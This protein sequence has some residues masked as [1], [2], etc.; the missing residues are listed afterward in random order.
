[1]AEERSAVGA[2]AAALGRWL[3]TYLV[4]LPV[5]LV[6]ASGGAG[7]IGRADPQVLDVAVLFAG[8]GLV[9]TATAVALRARPRPRWVVLVPPVALA[10]ADLVVGRPAGQPLWQQAGMV[11]LGVVGSAVLVLRRPAGTTP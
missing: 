5:L 11:T 3:A 10:G 8:A 1:M 7:L 6:L 4:G 9:V 2:V